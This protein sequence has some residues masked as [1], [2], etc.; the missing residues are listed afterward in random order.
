MI[1]RM[2]ANKVA[3]LFGPQDDPRI[4]LRKFCHYKEGCLDIIF[5]K[6]VKQ[7]LRIRLAWPVIKGQ[8]ENLAFIVLP[9]A[10]ALIMPE[11]E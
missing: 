5:I 11:S 4:L 10:Q 7:S 1:H 3:F 6:Q 9:A 2:N 8:I